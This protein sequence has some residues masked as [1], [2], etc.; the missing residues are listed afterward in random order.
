MKEV[1]PFLWFDNEAEEAAK[2][3]VLVF[4]GNSRI[5]TVTHYGDQGGKPKGSVMTV[6]FELNGQRF[7]ALNGGPQFKF[8][9]AVSFTIDCENQDEIDHFWQKLPA[10]G[11][12]I[13]A[14]GWLKDKYGVTWQVVPAVFW[15]WAD[16]GN[17]TAFDRVMTA[18]VTMTKLDLAALQRAWDGN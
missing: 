14:C 5:G 7:I 11:G 3:Y 8:N 9:E 15:E 16:S 12:E 10:D 13:I 6:T 2:F 4:G 18:L 1:T 17:P